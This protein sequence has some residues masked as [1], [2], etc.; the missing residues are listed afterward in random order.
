MKKTLEILISLL[1]PI[2]VAYA[3]EKTCV[4]ITYVVGD[5][6]RSCNDANGDIIFALENPYNSSAQRLAEQSKVEIER[7]CK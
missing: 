1:L 5:K 2:S 7:F 4:N 6:V 3:V